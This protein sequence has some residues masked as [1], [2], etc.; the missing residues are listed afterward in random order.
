[1]TLDK[2]FML[3]FL[4]HFAL[5]AALYAWLT[6]ERQIAVGKGEVTIGDFVNAGADPQRSKRVARNLSNQFELPIFAL[7]A[8]LFIY[9]S[10]QVSLIDVA[11]A[12]LFVAGRLAHTGVQTLTN[13]VKLRGIV[14]TLTF[15]G[16][17]ILMGRVAWIAL[18]T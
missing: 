10:R 3:A 14:Y 18:A 11:A 5:V 6:F 7:F 13:D 2:L 4:T 1:M 15:F 8:A 17:A 9:F 16:V 12:W